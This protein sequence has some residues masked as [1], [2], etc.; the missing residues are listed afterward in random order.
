MFKEL[1]LAIAL[2]SLLGF[3]VTGT[4]L[5]VKKNK[6]STSAN[7]SIP[8][9]TAAVSGAPQVATPTPSTDNSDNKIIV[10]SPENE[11]IVSNSQLT[12]KGTTN[13]NSTVVVS[14]PIDSYYSSSDEKG[15]FSLNVEIESGANQIQ[16]DSIDT[17]DN[18]I[19][20]QFLVTY[21]TAKI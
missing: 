15:N 2:G 9:P 6:P 18:Q 4:Y 17:D 7:I 16:I 3:G 1:I 11:T 21:S 10:I 8:T 14:T 19:T 20:S 12:V 5:A 13:P